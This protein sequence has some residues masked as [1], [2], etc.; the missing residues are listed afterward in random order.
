MYITV[1]QD[2]KETLGDLYNYK[3]KYFL[4]END[5]DKVNEKPKLDIQVDIGNLPIS[6]SGSEANAVLEPKGHSSSSAS[7][8]SFKVTL[9]EKSGKWKGQKIINLSKSPYD[10]SRIRNKLAFDLFKTIPNMFSLRTQFFHLYIKDLSGSSKQFIDYGLFTQVEQPNETYIKNHGLA[11]QG[12]LYK[13]EFFEFNRDDERIK[14]VDDPSYNKIEFEKVLKI[15][16]IEDHSLLIGMLDD[17]NNYSLNI[18]DVIKKHFDREN[19]L[20]WLAVNILTGNWDTNSQN[21]LLF[22]P[23]TAERWYFIP[24]DYD[25]AFG[26]ES[27][28]HEQELYA[29]W[30]TQPLSNY[31]GVKLHKRFISDSNNLKDLTQE[32]EEVSKYMSEEKVKSLVSKYY[33]QTSSIIKTLPDLNFIP[34]TLENYEKEIKRLPSVIETNKKRFYENI[35]TPMPIFLGIPEVQGNKTVFKWEES[36]DLKG[37]DLFYNFSLSTDPDF[38]NVVFNKDSLKDM[39]ITVENLAK[40][41]YYWKVDIYNSKNKHQI[42]FDLYHI[43]SGKSYYGEKELIIN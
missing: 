11:Q 33:S 30:Q 4:S 1:L 2:N 21:F 40:G 5:K 27:Q 7:Q 32:L 26:Y 35:D 23:I 36:Y 41:K 42:A 31:W 17:V 20:T 3:F 34:S 43:V 12:Y 38:K 29:P 6:I 13:A 28:P 19:Y 24:W 25:G 16:G 8:K 15:R 18:N 10:M 39:T 37:N 14:N 22:S 9:D